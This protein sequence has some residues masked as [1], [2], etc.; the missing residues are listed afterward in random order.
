MPSRSKVR[1]S[2]LRRG[3]AFLYRTRALL[4]FIRT[5]TENRSERGTRIWRVARRARERLV[6]WSMANKI[7]SDTWVLRYRGLRSMRIVLHLGEIKDPQRRAAALTFDFHFW[8]SHPSCAVGLFSFEKR[9]AGRVRA[10][11][12]CLRCG[13]FLLKE[14]TSS[15]KLSAHSFYRYKNIFIQTFL[16]FYYL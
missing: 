8:S 15:K 5:G 4:G 13:S 16:I 11:L 6:F 9:H 14:K 12:R 10:L 2:R 3:F 7:L 1:R